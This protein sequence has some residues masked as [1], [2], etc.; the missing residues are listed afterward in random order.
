MQ[1]GFL[2]FLLLVKKIKDRKYFLNKIKSEFRFSHIIKKFFIMKT[3][4]HTQCV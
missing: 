1:H 2:I 4:L 3:F